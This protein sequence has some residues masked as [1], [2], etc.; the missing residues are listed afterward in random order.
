MSINSGALGS[1]MALL[2][3]GSVDYGHVRCYQVHHR[4]WAKYSAVTYVASTV[5]PA[6]SRPWIAA[7]AAM[8]PATSA[9]SA[10]ACTS[11][12]H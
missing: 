3:S 1:G 9:N 12:L 5:S 2:A 11:V 10:N 8:Q 4:S 6:N 7:L